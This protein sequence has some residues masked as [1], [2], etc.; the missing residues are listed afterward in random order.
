MYC[1]DKTQFNV[2]G[3]HLELSNDVFCNIMS[4]NYL[5]FLAK[6]MDENYFNFRYLT[7]GFTA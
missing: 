4:I 7:S 6:D 2:M 5:K 3:F 1:V